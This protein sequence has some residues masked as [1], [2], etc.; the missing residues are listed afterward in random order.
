VSVVQTAYRPVRSAAMRRDPLGRARSAGGVSLLVAVALTGLSAA[1]YALAFPPVAARPLAWIAL[2][3]FLIALRDASVRRRLL[4]GMLWTL[5]VG[6]G[7]GTWMPSAV[8]DYF[9]Q[10]LAVGIALFLI[11]TGAMAAPYYTAFA[12]AYPPLVRRFAPAAPLLAGAAWAGAE[13]AR[14]RLLNGTLVY[15][16]NSPW[17]TFG[18]SQAGVAPLIQVASITGIYG[19]SFVL[20]VVNA[21]LAEMVWRLGIEQRVPR[22]AWNGV[23][24]ALATVGLTLAFGAVVLRAERRGPTGPA[25]VPIAIAQANLGAAARWGSEGAGRTL[26]AYLRLT[27]EALE[28]G[29]PAIVFWPEAAVTYFLE[30]DPLYGPALAAALRDRDV[31]LVVGAPRAGEADGA[32]PYTNS[33]YLI[34]A[35]GTLA[36][37]YDK[38][39]LL[40]FMEYF[41]LRLELARRRFGRIRE[42]TPGAPTPPLPTRAGKA[43]VLVCN[44][45]LLPHVAAERTAQ[46]AEYLIN[47]SNDSWV[48]NAGFAEQQLDIVSLRA[49]EQGTTL[50]RVSDSG[51][52]AVIDRFGRVLARTA[53]LTRAVLPATLVP[54]RV[55]TIYAAVGDVFGVACL[56]VVVLALLVSGRQR[57][58]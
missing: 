38:Q 35:G 28:R 53:P 55:G 22:S 2:V 4:L 9:H 54:R 5:A 32:P 47:P 10:P 6:W 24:L 29:K 1:L 51:P 15:V 18:Y 46:G 48:S 14:G 57:G 3:P 16:G 26:D 23:A 42:F 44:E 19:V 31:E 58:N 56:A 39:Y 36:G 11:V 50:V 52:S 40:P 25:P 13:L 7:V 27:R 43:G 45:A 37:R 41:P 17:A 33:V 34:A 30:Q 12:C 21:A 20:V 49:V 8:S